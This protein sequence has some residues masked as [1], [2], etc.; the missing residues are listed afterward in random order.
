MKTKCTQ[1][2]TALFVLCISAALVLT[3]PLFSA[4]KP[5][6]NL[7]IVTGEEVPAKKNKSR[8]KSLSYRNNVSVKIYPDPIKKMMHVVAKA[9]KSKEIDFFLFDMEGTLLRNYK[10]KAKEHIRIQG[11]QKG[12][13]IYRVFCGDEETA[14]G[15]FIIK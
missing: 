14:S 2:K 12:S 1:K 11:L 4:A 10:L 15:N 7:R 13:Y 3:T 6:I 8:V 5:V 9:N